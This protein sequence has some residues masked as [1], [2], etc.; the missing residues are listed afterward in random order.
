[1]TTPTTS[2]RP[3]WTA[4]RGTFPSATAPFP[5]EACTAAPA[6]APSITPRPSSRPRPCPPTSASPAV[7]SCA[8][9]TSPATATALS[10]LRPTGPRLSTMLSCGRSGG[11]SPLTMTSTASRCAVWTSVMPVLIGSLRLWCIA[12]QR[13]G[14]G[15]LIMAWG[16]VQ[17][18]T[19][20]RWDRGGCSVF[21]WL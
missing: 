14:R 7:S 21:D 8:R 13:W 10:S 15:A 20:H 16:P 4:A 5:M 17:D 19:H 6:W 11:C 18:R 2:Q 3:V 9:I 12:S 1:M